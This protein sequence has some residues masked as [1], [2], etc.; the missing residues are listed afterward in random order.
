MMGSKLIRTGLFLTVALTALPTFAQDKLKLA[1]GQRGNWDSAV[2]E[3]GQRA[4]IF[5]KQGL[6]LE[7]LWTQGSGETIQ[8]VLSQSVDVGVA[9][10]IMGTLGA[11]S[12]G[13]PIRVIGAQSTGAGDLFWYVREDSPVKTMKDMDGKTIAYSTNG[14]STHGIVTAFINEM[15]LKARP[16]AT[17]SPSSTLTQVMS[18]QVDMGW[19]APPSSLDFIDQKKIRVI[20][21]GNDTAFKNQTVRLL[22]VHAQTLQSKKPQLERF[23][24]AYRETIDRMYDDPAMLKT[25]AEFAGVSEAI[26]KRTRDEF[27]AKSAID[28]DKVV[29]LAEIMPDAVTYKYIAAPLTEAQTKD[30]F[31][32]IPR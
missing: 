9:A 13:A 21:T 4:G 16:V 6:E 2:P 15:K 32:I 11:F 27:F 18:G 25:Y 17:G 3:I 22:D 24:K 23:M 31:Q 14:S 10:G 20:A 5:K 1:V 8:A 26:A 7:I 30:L 12:K 19:S 28:P 29:G